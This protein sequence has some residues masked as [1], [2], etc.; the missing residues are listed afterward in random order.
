MFVIYECGCIG[1]PPNEHGRAIIV[2]DLLRTMQTR[3]ISLLEAADRL[4]IDMKLMQMDLEDQK[5]NEDE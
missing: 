2:K 3:M 4:R 5:E 1:F